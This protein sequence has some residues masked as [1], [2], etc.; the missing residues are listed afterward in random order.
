R[1]LVRQVVHGLEPGPVTV[2]QTMALE[3]WRIDGRSLRHQALGDVA[4]ASGVLARSV[5]DQRHK[6]RRGRRPAAGDDARVAAFR[7]RRLRFAA[8]AIVVR[9]QSEFAATPSSLNSSAKPRVH[10]LMPYLAIA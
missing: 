5:R 1:Q 3:V 2:R 4:V 8:V 7:P 6:P 9:G 10:M